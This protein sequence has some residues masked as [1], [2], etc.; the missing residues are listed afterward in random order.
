MTTLWLLSALAI[1]YLGVLFGVA[2]FGER[3]SVYPGR[4]RLRPII[5]SLALGVY[6]TTW[7]FFGAVGTAATR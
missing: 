7:T 4:T 5:Y 1:T 3:Y 6:C 2:F